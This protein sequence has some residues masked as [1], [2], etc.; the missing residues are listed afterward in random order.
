MNGLPKYMSIVKAQ[1]DGLCTKAMAGEMWKVDRRQVH[2]WSVRRNKNGF[3]PIRAVYVAG[4]RI[5]PLFN[6]KE[7]L[8]WK[9]NYDA[10][11]PVDRVP[12][13]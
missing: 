12:A 4:S 10:K 7:L 5:F 3:P 8:V 13:A 6:C 9:K 11:I 1:A 2:T